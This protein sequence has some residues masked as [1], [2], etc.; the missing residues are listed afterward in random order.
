MNGQHEAQTADFCTLFHDRFLL[1]VT[2]LDRGHPGFVLVLNRHVGRQAA[3]CSIRSI[4]FTII[5]E[6]LERLDLFD[7]IFDRM[8]I[9]DV[10]TFVAK[11]AVQCF[12]EC[13][14]RRFSET[15]EVKL[16]VV[17]IRLFDREA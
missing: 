2:D 10:Q 5:L 11:A 13:I 16:N 6:R 15:G 9:V 3:K 12:D 17:L 1:W 4:A 7:R 14:I 8:Q